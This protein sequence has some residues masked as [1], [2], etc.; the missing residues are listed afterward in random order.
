MPLTCVHFSHSLTDRQRRKSV[1]RTDLLHLNQQSEPDVA[2]G[3]TIKNCPKSELHISAH[4]EQPNDESSSDSSQQRLLRRPLSVWSFGHV[5]VAANRHSVCDDMP[6][7]LTAR[8]RWRLAT[9]TRQHTV[10][11]GPVMR[12]AAMLVSLPIDSEQPIREAMGERLKKFFLH[13]VCR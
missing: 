2:R 12:L 5:V 6:F 13:E 9:V 3:R 8:L 7:M 11:A 10:L 1:A 4:S